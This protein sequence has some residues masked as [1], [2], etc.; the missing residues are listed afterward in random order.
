MSWYNPGTGAWQEVHATV[1]P[2]TRT[3]TAEVAHFSLFALMW[4]AAPPAEA[5]TGPVGTVPG[6]TPSGSEQPTEGE[7]PWALIAAAVLAAG[8]YYLRKQ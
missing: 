5:T 8:W 3:L 6:E 1:D 4:T 2:A 7:A